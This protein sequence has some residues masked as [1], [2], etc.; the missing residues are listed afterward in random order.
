MGSGNTPP[1]EPEPPNLAAVI[2]EMIVGER[3]TPTPMKMTEFKKTNK[4]FEP[5]CQEWLK[6]FARTFGPPP[7]ELPPLHEVNHYIML[8]DPDV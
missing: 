3:P 6:K 4:E 5:R 1:G 7:P 2:N 8:I